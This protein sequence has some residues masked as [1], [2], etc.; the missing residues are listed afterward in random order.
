MSRL[1]VYHQSLPEQP[2]KVLCHAD[3]IARTL[4][5]VGVGLE[6]WSVP[7]AVVLGLDVAT[8]TNESQ[9]LLAPLL[10]QGYVVD[11]VLSLKAADAQGLV[12][13]ERFADEFCLDGEHS[14]LFLAGRGLVSLHIE[15]Y[16]YEVLCERGDLL[17]LPAGTKH[18]VDFGERANMA[19]IRLN[20]PT[21]G[22]TVRRTGD[23][24]ASQFSRLEEWA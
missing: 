15:D 8:L 24:I 6:Q 16:V 10:A 22:V 2:N 19:V 3:D 13:R 20:K 14:S 23:T 11:E 21:Q 18:W 12:L 17:T 7:A 1:S 5:E 4:A 9:T